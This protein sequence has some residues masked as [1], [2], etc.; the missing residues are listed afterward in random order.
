MARHWTL[1]LALGLASCGVGGGGDDSGGNGGSGGGSA[2]PDEPKAACTAQLTVSGTFTASGAL[3]PTAGCQPAG[4]WAVT[5]SVASMGDCTT[6]PVK[7]SYSYTVSGAGRDTQL[8][9]TKASGE[10]FTGA[11]EATG[12]GTCEG[13][14]DHVV[15][16][17][18]KFDEINLHPSLAKVTDATQTTL[19]I[20]GTGTY[21]LWN[22]HP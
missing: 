17:G 8:M 20:T 9:Y 3:D 18:A 12:T 2:P 10:D 11:V 22:A 16:N 5:V 1:V 6:V 19:T 14:F 4:T 15:T 13:S 21:N 7:T